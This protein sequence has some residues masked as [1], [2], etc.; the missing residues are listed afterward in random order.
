[1][2]QKAIKKRP[3]VPNGRAAQFKHKGTPT[4]RL[5]HDLNVARTTVPKSG[6]LKRRFSRL[7]TPL[8]HANHHFLSN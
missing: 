8:Y 1:V 2:V 5:V 7:K 4:G 3:V 6:C